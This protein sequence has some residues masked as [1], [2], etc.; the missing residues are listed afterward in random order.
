MELTKRQ[1]EELLKTP[2]IVPRNGYKVLSWAYTPTQ[3]NGSSDYPMKV[4]RIKHDACGKEFLMRRNDFVSKQRRC[5]HCFATP[6]KTHENFLKSLESCEDIDEY[7]V[8]SQYD[9]RSKK[10]TFFHKKC[11]RSFDMTPGH[12]LAGNRCPRCRESQ[13]EKKLAKIISALFPKMRR[14]VHIGE[15]MHVDFFD[16]EGTS[17]EYDGRQHFLPIFPDSL[18]RQHINDIK[19]NLYFKNNKK[20]LIRIPYYL[21]FQEIEEIIKN[22]EITT[23]PRCLIIRNGKVYNEE[24]Y[25]KTFIDYPKGVGPKS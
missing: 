16:D 6:K 25:Y 1:K 19:K 8:R 21:S 22:K 15:R 13:S 18:K 5:P 20:D 10:V 23:D 14:E 7:E 11:G 9:G 12:F 3:R 4:L 17:I 24:I 2:D